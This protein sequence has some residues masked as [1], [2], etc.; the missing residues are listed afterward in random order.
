MTDPA[1]EQI[2]DDTV[3]A[4]P[5]AATQRSRRPRLRPDIMAVVFVGGCLGGSARYAATTVW[6]TPGGRFPWS[7]F[8]VNVAGAF[9]LAL[10]VVAAADL[11]PSRYVRALLGTG[12]CGAL[13]TF[14]S[15]V[16]G[17][18]QLFAH[19]RPAT[20]VAYLLATMG[21]GIGAASLGLVLGR[22]ILVTHGRGERGTR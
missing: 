11:A 13:T 12:F 22:W 16:V 20:A 7:T 14:S 15:V 8:G 2:R 6:P 1:P 19:H 10:V 5:F 17:V 21:A 4:S 9:I 3:S 18:D